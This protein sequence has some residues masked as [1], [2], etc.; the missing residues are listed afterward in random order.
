VKEYEALDVDQWTVLVLSS[1]ITGLL[2]KHSRSCLHAVSLT[3]TH[4]AQCN[5]QGYRAPDQN[6]EQQVFDK[7]ASH[8]HLKVCE[9]CKLLGG[10]E[11]VK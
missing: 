7:E 1:S 8:H 9:H 5:T 11:A 6:V 2:T 3:P 10:S 4:G